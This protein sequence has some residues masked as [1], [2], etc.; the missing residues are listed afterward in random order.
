MPLATATT[1]ERALHVGM[2]EAAAVRAPASLTCVLGSCVG[3]VLYHPRQRIGAMAHVVLPESA[4]RAGS[5]GKFADTAIPH[6]LELLKAA[7]APAAGLIAKISGGASMFS[8]G[9]PL[10]VGESNV[11]AVL[12]ALQSVHI[13][14]AAQHV[15]GN[16][17]RRVH[18]DS[19]T[20]TLSVEVV[21]C[22]TSLL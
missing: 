18:L 2:G 11:Q 14:L 4:G 15:G 21:G 8:S 22:P 5:P 12:K 3:V 20:G 9:G 17:G 13:S 6:L 7:G 19:A 10:Q 16:K 1:T